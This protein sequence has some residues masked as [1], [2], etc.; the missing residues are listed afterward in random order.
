MYFG[1]ILFVYI[2]MHTLCFLIMKGALNKLHIDYINQKI[3][4]HLLGCDS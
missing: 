1:Y 4:L 2:V 3:C